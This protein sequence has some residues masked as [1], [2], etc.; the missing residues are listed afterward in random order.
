MKIVTNTFSGVCIFLLFGLLNHINAQETVFDQKRLEYFQNEGSNLNYYCE[1][2]WAWLE[3]LQNGEI[4]GSTYYVTDVDG[5]SKPVKDVIH[6]IIQ[7]WGN[8]WSGSGYPTYTWAW[9][10]GPQQSSIMLSW[11]LWRYSNEIQSSDRDFIY[12]LLNKDFRSRDFNVANPNSQIADMITRYLWSQDNQDVNVIYSYDPPPNQNIYEFTWEDRTYTPGQ[13][14]NSFA[15]CRDRLHYTIYRWLHSGNGEFD[16]PVY[17]WCFVHCFSALYEWAKDP[18]MKQKAKMMVDFILLDSILDFTANQWGG[19]LGRKYE[20]VFRYAGTDRFYWDVFWDMITPTHEPPRNI[21]I[22]SYW[23]PSEIFDIGDL[24]DE[25]DNYYH[26][27]KEFNS[28][29]YCV[30]GTGK[31]NWVTKFYSLGGGRGNEWQ[32]CIKSDKPGTYGREFATPFRLWINTIQEGEDM[33]DW[34]FTSGQAGYQYQNAIFVGGTVLHISTGAY[35]F[36]V[37]QETSGWRFL[38]EGRTMV[39]III[40]S[41]TSGVEVAIEGVD[42]GS[43]DEFKQAVLTNASIASSTFTTSRGDVISCKQVKIDDLYPSVAI[44]KKNG[45]SEFQRVWDFPFPR[46]AAVDYRGNDI[47]KWVGNNM[48]VEKNGK[49]LTYDFDNWTVAESDVATDTVAP[50]PP[51]NVSVQPAE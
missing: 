27:D 6:N 21:F 39:A 29:I 2:I 10:F 44:V 46:V 23:L 24:S 38:K 51:N 47:V 37:D 35:S 8:P 13:E 36:D 33:T 20:D 41:S 15:L 30:G 11:I 7:C 1:R 45:E 43:F 3:K 17:T 12:N 50:S 9:K 25:P 40:G 26:I 31:W 34:T 42:Y 16:S 22:S 4:N 5:Q 14:Y 32:L 18:L 28:G 49:R 48:I 19:A